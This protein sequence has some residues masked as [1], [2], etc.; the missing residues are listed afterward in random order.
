MAAGEVDTRLKVTGMDCPGCAKTVEDSLLKVDGVTDV[1][2]SVVSEVAKVRHSCDT[3]SYVQLQQAIEAAGYG[4]LPDAQVAEDGK[5]TTRIDREKILTILS[6]TALLA[7][8]AIRWGI[9]ES[10]LGSAW[11]GNLRISDAFYILSALLGGMNFFPAALRAAWTLSLDMNFLMT[12]AIIGAGIIGEYA[13]AATIAFLFSTAEILEEYAVGRARRSLEALMELAPEEATVRRDGSETIV[14]VED[15]QL[16]DCVLV[17]PGERIP[18]DGQ[19]VE[20]VSAVDQSPI[21][22]ESIPV[23]KETGEEVYAGT[24]N[25]EG[26]LE[27]R[28]TRVARDSR[29]STI[30]RMV[31]EAEER[32]A[33]SEQ[34]VKRFARVYTPFV[35]V[36]ALFVIVLPPFLFDG[37]FATW[38]VRGLT[39]L[40]IACP[41]ALVI[42]TPVAVVSGITSAARNGVLIKGGNYLEAL[43][44]VKAVAFDKTGTLTK[45]EIAV[46]DV[47]A[48]CGY[49]EE[50]V[51]SL[52]AAL[53]KHSQ[54]PIGK[55]ICVKA[56]NG[57]LQ[58]V[59]EFE[60]VTGKGVRG[61]I[62]GNRH[63][64][65]KPSLWT[66]PPPDVA[67]QLQAEGKTT[68]LVGTENEIIGV[69]G[70]ADS[71][72]ENAAASV[73]DM[74]SEG[75][76][77]VVMLT[78]D[79]EATAAAIGQR[80]GVDG[81][82]SELLP[83]E[84][85][86]AIEELRLASGR[87]S[88]VGDGVNDA[89]ALASADVG[90]AMG[91][92]GTDA[93][94]ETA[95]VA[96]MSDD[97]SRLPYLFRLSRQARRVMRQNVILSI[98][99]KFV[100]AVGVIPG[101]VSLVVA[102]LVGDMGMSLG[103]TL[104]SARLARIRAQS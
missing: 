33:P 20:G 73:A 99:V 42:S 70:L 78:G 92:A 65:G 67:N 30:V 84:K 7:G 62:D 29:L 79:N 48:L 98:L 89:P 52:A 19:V 38:F 45:G 83:E 21:T 9:P 102:V 27:L 95:D 44:D 28:A 68:A 35:T 87:V 64:V 88:M 57:P 55:A 104:N 63:V 5:F 93:A 82:N 71:I 39:L 94:L 18:V 86:E 80:A 6:G 1:T 75:I 22:G 14:S 69:I 4:V 40:V 81:W 17:R 74:R 37:D 32:R 16:G 50:E 8:L 24:I 34:F 66:V 3:V 15:V 51:L 46:T 10:G 41:C 96:L 72:R 36:L 60:S 97:L 77:Q 49:A 23:T 31:E 58:A 56:G 26:Y 61:L 76:R 43:G 101:Y 90:I 54:H 2:V 12:V 11:T 91:A 25:C 85:V 53:E 100:L 59:T 103:V 47:I 13:E